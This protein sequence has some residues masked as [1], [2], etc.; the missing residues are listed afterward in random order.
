MNMTLLSID[1]ESLHHILQNLYAEFIPMAD[2]LIGAGRAIAGTGAVLY[3]A[4]RVWRHIA[5]AEPID[6]YPL[7]RPFVIGFILTIYSSFIGLIN[8][9]G[10]PVVAATESIVSAQKMDL[11]K[12]KVLRK[13]QDEL[14]IEKKKQVLD[15]ATLWSKDKI[16]TT[17]ANGNPTTIT[18]DAFSAGGDLLFSQLQIQ[19]R[20]MMYVALDFT[21]QA[22][23]LAID[24]LRTFFLI[25]L[26]II[27]PISLGIAV[28]D[29]FK[30]TLQFWVAR[31]IVIF[32]WLPVANIFTGILSK[33]QVLMLTKAISELKTTG[34][35]AFSSSDII[36]MIFMLIG[37]LGY[38]SVPHVAGF[39]VQSCG[40]GNAGRSIN[41]ASSSITG[42]VHGVGTVAGGMYS[43]VGAVAGRAAAGATN[44]AGSI[45]N[46]RA[47]YNSEK[48]NTN[49]IISRAGT[50]MGR[51]LNK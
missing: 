25:V 14:M 26:V 44:L 5:N 46:L 32:M 15:Q 47:G 30:D 22:A 28:W 27:G 6:F 2:N 16:N 51:F 12:F 31:Y 21:F 35:I 50:A 17:D 13:Q 48:Q 33:I 1:W 18:T 39:I 45:G 24:T 3:V 42:G 9:I 43:G 49:G 11:D 20:E 23:S 7:F 29:G 41:M 34:D 10:Q 40:L 19:I 36:Y 37:I 8:G 4:S 38:A